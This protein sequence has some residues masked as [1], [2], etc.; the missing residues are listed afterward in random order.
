MCVPIHWFTPVIP[1]MCR[2][3]SGLRQ[4]LECNP[5]IPHEWQKLHDLSHAGCIPGGTF[6]GRECPE[7]KLGFQPWHANVRHFYEHR[8]QEASAAGQFLSSNLSRNKETE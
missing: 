1:T 7:L 3:G 4:E 6:T 2:V 8:Y 5:G